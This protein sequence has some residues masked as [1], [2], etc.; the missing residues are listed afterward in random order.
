M[1]GVFITGTSTDVGKTY[2][3]VLLC[4]KLRQQAVQII[5]KKPVESGCDAHEG[6]LVPHDASALK[7]A[8]EYPGPVS[9]ICHSC[10]TASVSPARAAQ[11]SNTKLSIQQLNDFCTQD[12]D[13]KFML[14]EGAGG[15][16]S[17]LVTDGLNADLAS[18]LQLPVILVSNNKLGCIND[19]L[20]CAE[21]I[22]NRGLALLAVFLTNQEEHLDS[23][24]NNAEDL[25][26]HLSCPIIS[27]PHHRLGDA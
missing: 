23:Q 1:A 4:K 12:S 13:E 8:A 16:Y 24:M 19:V 25:Q 10:F 2:I 20:L 18:A 7:V 21:A 26:Q 6:K 3:G 14:I 17:P 9:D 11:L 22:H 15:F 5:P 27:I